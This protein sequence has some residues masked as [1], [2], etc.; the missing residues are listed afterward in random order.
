MVHYCTLDN[1]LD[2]CRITVD[3]LGIREMVHF[4]V[5]YA[6]G[7][8]RPDECEQTS[9]GFCGPTRQRYILALWVRPTAGE[10]ARGVNTQ[11]RLCALPAT[12]HLTNPREAEADISRS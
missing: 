3:A 2:L 6:D 7:V 11:A 4:R 8:A 10:Q 5:G 1:L 9:I 12:V